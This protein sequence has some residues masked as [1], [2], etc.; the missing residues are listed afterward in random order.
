MLTESHPIIRRFLRF[1]AL[2]YCY[3]KLVN[4]SEC[5]SS[6]IQVFKDLLYIFFKLKYFPDNYGPCRLWEKDREEWT[7]YYGSSYNSYPRNKLRKKVQPFEYQLLFDD[8]SVCEQLCKGIDVI[9]PKSFGIIGSFDDFQGKIKIVFENSKLDKLIIKPILGH[10]GRGILLATKNQNIIKIISGNSE[11]DLADFAIDDVY[12]IQE[13][14]TQDK[15]I[16]NI[17]SSSINTIRVVTLYTKSNEVIVISST[18]RFGVGKSYVDNWSAGG[19][20]VGV[21][22]ETGR[23]KEVA[24]DKYGNQHLEHPVSKVI[25][26]NFQIPMWEL[27]VQT[28]VKVQEAC[29]FY[30]LLGMDIAVSKDGPVL[31]EVN[32]NS[33]IVF[34]EQTSGPLLK[35]KRVLLGFAEYELLINKLQRN[36]FKEQ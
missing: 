12:I 33:D 1:L 6:R 17:S 34:Q 8:K 7:F 23:L 2:P 29:P 14:V 28:A 3:F 31:I 18:M 27:V 9:M 26:E 30:K 35:D 11:N 22:H 21:V 19:I 25:F 4:W 36:L 16:S 5:T 10:A 24:Y 15:R 13:V 32:A 20:A